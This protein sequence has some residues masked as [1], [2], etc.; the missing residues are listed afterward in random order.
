MRI[1]IVVPTINLWTKYTKQ[2][3]E[4]IQI[5]MVRAKEHSIDSRL[6]LIDNQ[7]TDE[8]IQEAG[9][10][11]SEIFSHKRNEERWGFQK[12]VNFGINDAFSRGYDIVLVCN[13]DIVIHPEAIWRLTER[14]SKGDVGMV[15][16]LDVQG[17]MTVKNLTATFI[18]TLNVNEKLSVEEAPHPNFSAFAITKETWDTVGEFDEL[19]YPAYFEDND[20]HYRMKLA[21]IN[22]IVLPTAMFYHYGSRTQNEAAENGMPM[23][24]GGMFENARGAYVRKW[25]GKPGEETF[26]TP[27]NNSISL[28]TDTK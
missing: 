11:V 1:Q 19:Y 15:T 21:N 23:V 16:C 20:F 9:K 17:E 10:M 12:S 8:T 18:D 22:A 28:I 5:A 4:S 3:L 24:S 14:F 27:Y 2:C 13:N 6:L 7:S 26:T 25:G